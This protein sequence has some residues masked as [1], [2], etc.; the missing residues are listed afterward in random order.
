MPWVAEYSARQDSF[1]IQRL[2]DA[3]TSNLRRALQKD[4]SND[5]VPV[6]VG[7]LESVGQAVDMIRE[8]QAR[9]LRGRRK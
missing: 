8:A 4:S 7:D 3:L 9:L 6:A 2:T 5:W 1:H